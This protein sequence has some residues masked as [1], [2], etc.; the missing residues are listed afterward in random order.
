LKGDVACPEVSIKGIEEWRTS[1]TPDV[2]GFKRSSGKDHSHGLAN[3]I[4]EVIL[5]VRVTFLEVDGDCNGGSQA[6]DYGGYDGGLHLG[7]CDCLTDRVEAQGGLAGEKLVMILMEHS[8]RVSRLKDISAILI[9]A[10]EPKMNEK[11]EVSIFL[12][13]NEVV[14]MFHASL[15][16]AASGGLAEAEAVYRRERWT[17]NLK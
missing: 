7:E 17:R 2:A 15:S 12:L 11:A 1:Q 16:L 8:D 4:D 10:Q 13:M 9:E 14:L 3:P 6:K 5:C